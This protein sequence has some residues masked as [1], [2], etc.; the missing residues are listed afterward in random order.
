MLSA[1][2]GFGLIMSC[3]LYRD[4]KVTRI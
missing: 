1:M 2:I 3:N 4:S